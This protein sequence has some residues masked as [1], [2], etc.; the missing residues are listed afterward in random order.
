MGRSHGFFI[1]ICMIGLGVL[2]GCGLSTKNSVSDDASRFTT[3]SDTQESGTSAALTAARVVFKAKCTQCHPTFGTLKEADWISQGYVV[4]GLPQN[5]KIFSRIRGSGVGGNEDMPKDG[6]SL[7]AEQL[8]TI[9][10]WIT[11]MTAP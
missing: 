11:N 1:S 7:S 5:S 4:V 9:K 3:E 10:G 6:S 2:S 8:D